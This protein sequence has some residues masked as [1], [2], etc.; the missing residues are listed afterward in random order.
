MGC[1]AKPHHTLV[2]HKNVRANVCEAH[3]CNEMGQLQYELAALIGAIERILGA[4]KGCLELIL[5]LIMNRNEN[6]VGRERI[7]RNES[8]YCE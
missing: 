4:Q 5:E 8:E 2:L 7:L 1:G 3:R 6:S